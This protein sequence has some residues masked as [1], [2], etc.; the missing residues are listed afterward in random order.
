MSNAFILVSASGGTQPRGC[1]LR[2]RA[3]FLR[4]LFFVLTLVVVG[5]SGTRVTAAQ[6]PPVPPAVPPAPPVPPVATSIAKLD[7]LLQ[8]RASNSTGYSQVIV[9]ARDAVSLDS[10]AAL[11]Q[12]LGGSLG[13]RLPIIDA[14][15]AYVPNA[16]LLL[17]ANSQTVKRIALD[18]LVLGAIDATGATVGAIATRQQFGYDGAGIGV[19]VID[20][21]VTNWHDD[22]TEGGHPTFQRVHSFI[23]FVAGHPTPYDD[24]G[25]GTH[26]AGIIAGNGFDSVGGR[27]GIAP[28]AHLFVFKVL[29]GSGHGRIS[30]VIG[31]FDYIIK[32]QDLLRVRVIN[33]SIGA[34]VYESYNSDFLTLAAKRAV[35]QGII[36]VAA[37]GN[38]GKDSQNRPRYRSITAPGNAPWVLTVGASS[39]MGTTDRADDAMAEFSSRGPTSVDYA[40]KPDLV[41]P[42]VGIESLSDPNSLFYTSRSPYLLNG[43][44][45]TSYLPYLSLSGTSQAAPVV[46]GVVALMLQANPAL[47]P[48][49]VKAILQYTSQRYE[50]YDALTQGAGFLNGRGAIEL[51]RFFKS[52]AGQYPAFA[53]EW[54]RQIIWGNHSV[55]GGVLWPYANAWS[56][57]LTWGSAATAEGN[58]VEWGLICTG[59]SCETSW[60]SWTTWRTCTGAQCGVAASSTGSSENVV[61]G[62]TC[63][64]DDCSTVAAH[65]VVWGNSDDDTVVWGNTDDD[66]VV[67]GNS[68]DDTVVWGNTDEDEAVVWSTQ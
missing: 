32:Y 45:A 42:G 6:L 8:P 49:A 50:G 63:G 21:G 54:S 25:H 31:A 53:P 68:D 43:T 37:A 56:S 61:W 51:A 24:Y 10:V 27:S 9:R 34:G 23:D 47:T 41:A 57:D 18:R 17:L 38:L 22:L 67:W 16:A 14:Q 3:I 19:A 29:D 7:P 5:T 52:P 65:T 11:I 48:N 66:T 39:H 62:S 55:R 13:L 30:D 58:D 35:E 1:F 59:Q 28:A 36:V 44:V 64:G 4:S 2:K 33:L 60:D 46:A 20:S 15:A 26:V 12:N 40:A